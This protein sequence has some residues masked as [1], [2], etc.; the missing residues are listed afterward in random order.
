VS[1]FNP[2]AIKPGVSR[3]VLGFYGSVEHA[4]EALHEIRKNRFRRSAVVQCADDGVLNFLYAGLSPYSRAALAIAMAVALVLLGRGLREERWEQVLLASCGFLVTWFGS[5]WLGWGL[6]KKL[7]RH[8][9]RF[10]LPGES[11]VVVQATEVDTPPVIE[12][13]RRISHPSVFAI[14]PGL[15][16]ASSRQPDETLRDPVTLATLP[17]C[18]IELAASH[19]LNVSTRSRPLLPILRECE[20]AI[21]SARADLGEAARLDYGIAHAAEWLLDNTYL[22]RSHIAEIRH[23]LPDNHARILP[24][25]ADTSSSVRFRIY[26]IA[27]DLIS[28]TGH[29]VATESIVSYLN[30]Y[31][32]KAP[33]TIAELWVFPLMLRMVLLQRLQWSSELASRRQHQK[34]MADFWANRLLNAAQRGPEQ[35][36]KIITELDRD[37]NELTPHFIARLGEQLHKEELSLAPIQKWIEAKT[38][39]R[40]ADINLREHAEEANDLMF[41][42]TAIGSLRHLSELQY[43]KIVEAVSRLE[44]ILR[45]DP[46]GIHASSDFDTRD[47]CRRI[48]EETARHSKSTEWNV[49]RLAVEL[50]QSGEQGSREGCVAFYLL[51]DG[52]A[53]LERR[54]GRR[55]LWRE[56]RLRFLY[57]H[58]VLVYLGGLATLTTG[59]VSTFLFVAHAVRVSSPSILLLLGTLALLPASELALYLVQTLLTWFVPPR[60]LPK[61]SFD[62]GI[63]E[64]CRTL[65]V[66]PMMLLTEDSILGEIDKLEVR[67]LANSAANLYFSLLADFTDAEECEMPEDDDLLGLAIKGIVQ[68]NARHG[69][70]TFSLLHRSRTWCETERRWIGWERKRG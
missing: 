30:A 66:V 28:R 37:G 56:R 38:G 20:V 39:F 22:I 52:L 67:Y 29:R 25:I 40:L 57:R 11:L 59:I 15:R 63:P 50:A 17:D 12:V 46:S 13:L 68:L 2:S 61:M 23:N 54:V 36:E 34:E 3:L 8:Y 47:R 58:P 33:L 14:R 65:V 31:Q 55:L 49:A 62:P 21:E 9:G 60:T 41:I 42:S 27:A 70:G 10:L 51:D 44:A 45:E 5:L 16:L 35:F 64:D 32:Q 18:A 7:L 6:Q 69:A 48:V 4:E 26:H 43:P 53:Q 24:L 19:Q 1:S